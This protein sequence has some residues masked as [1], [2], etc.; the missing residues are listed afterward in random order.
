[1][2]TYVT[3][4]ETRDGK[5]R[6]VKDTIPPLRKER[7]PA[8]EAKESPGADNAHTPAKPVKEGA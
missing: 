8:A 1:M 7:E 3:R 2:A 6:R 4:Y 5:T